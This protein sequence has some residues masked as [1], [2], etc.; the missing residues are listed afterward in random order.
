LAA[1]VL[2]VSIYFVDVKGRTRFTKPGIV[3]G[4][5]AITVYVLADVWAQLFY[6][7]KIAGISLNNHFLNGFENAGWSLKFGS[8]LYALLFIGFNFIPA[9]ILYKKKIFIKL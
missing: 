9:W 2:A 7:L 1:M 6:N 4:S 3:F 5:N 8:F